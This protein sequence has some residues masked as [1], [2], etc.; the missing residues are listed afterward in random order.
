MNLEAKRELDYSVYAGELFDLT[1]KDNDAYWE[2]V[3]S[4]LHWIPKFDLG[5]EPRILDLGAGTG[6]FTLAMHE[7]IPSAKFTHLDMSP[8]MNEQAKHKYA[9]RG[10][11]VRI[12]ESLIQTAPLHKN[13]FDLVVS[14]NALNTAPPQGSTIRAIHNW[15]RPS[16]SLFLVDFGRVI[17]TAAWT[18]YL[19]AR[20]IRKNGVMYTAKWFARVLESVTQNR[21]AKRDQ[22]NGAMWLHSTDELASIVRDSGFTVLHSESCYR[23]DSDIVIAQCEKEAEC[24]S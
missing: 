22:K 2:M 17:N 23:G 24:S 14:V 1:H 11:T 9:E 12:I 19:V 15:L 3:D 18:R 7:L 4:L 13:S 16:G 8:Q 6:N 5:P 21:K 10:V 20:N